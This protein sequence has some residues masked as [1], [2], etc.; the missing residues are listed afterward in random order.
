MR[1]RA[2]V[3]GLVLGLGLA[4]AARAADPEPCRG[5]PV[6]E[7]AEAFV[8]EQV[9]YRL[10]I[11]TRDDVVEVDWLEPPSFPGFRAERLPGS[12]QPARAGA[13]PRYRVREEHRALFAEH[14]GEHALHVAGLRCRLRDGSQV[15]AQ[16]PDAQLRVRD[17]PLVGRPD[18]FAGLV[19]PLALR[20]Q[21]T[22]RE[23]SLGG[24]VRVEILLQGHGN[25]WDAPEPLA[26]AAVPG[27]AE[28]F[29]ERPQ[30]TLEKGPRL[31]VRRRF[32]YDLV[33]RAPGLLALPPVRIDYF[34]PETGSY[35]QA[36]GPSIELRVAAAPLPETPP[37]A[38]P[39]TEPERDPR[40]DA[41]DPEVRLESDPEPSVRVAAAVQ[42]ETSDSEEAL[43]S[44]LRALG[45]PDPQVV[46]AA[47]QAL[48][49]VGDETIV[50]ELSRYQNHPDPEVREALDEAIA[51]LE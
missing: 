17:L 14:A 31:L 48:E 5:R 11:L 38:P 21:A 30:L 49:F 22:P 15:V 40:L 19:G 18:G 1:S 2:P 24:S 46:V 45:D 6:L 41:L 44:L 4:A 35:A 42:L 50:P 29:R 16:V 13:D 33:P 12:P 37:A 47:I 7:P 26:E 9:L 3:L 36:S 43:Q 32:A 51:F 10:R 27:G 23:L 20:V 8:G 39:R 34:D 28:L 25:L